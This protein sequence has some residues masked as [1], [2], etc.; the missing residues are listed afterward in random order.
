MPY[1]RISTSN[2]ATAS[3]TFTLSRNPF[4]ATSSFATRTLIRVIWR[5][6]SWGYNWPAFLTQPSLQWGDIIL[7]IYLTHGADPFVAEARIAAK[8]MRNEFCDLII[9]FC[10]LKR[11]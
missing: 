5:F 8:N 11:A 3:T 2:P 10:D 9:D 6:A 7:I 1:N 4:I